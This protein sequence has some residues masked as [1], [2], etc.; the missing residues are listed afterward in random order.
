[1]KR[2]VV[3]GGGTGTTVTLSGLRTYEDIDLS[4]IVNMVD[5]GG[6]NRVVRDEFGLLPLSDLR[7]SI[8]ALAPSGNDILRQ[9]FTFRFSKGRG[10]KGHTL[11]NLVMIGLSEMRGGEVEAIEAMRTLFHVKGNVLPASLT[12]TTLVATYDDGAVVKGEHAIDEPE[13]PKDKKIVKV[14]LEPKP[15]PYERAIE[16]ILSSDVIIVGP[17]DLYTTIIAALLVP[18]M[19]EAIQSS[20]AKLVFVTNLMTKK[21]QTH[22]MGGAHMVT[23]LAKYTGREPDVVLLHRGTLPEKAT[24]AYIEKGEHPIIDDFSDDTHY[25]VVR[26]DLA[27]REEVVRDTGDVLTRSLV[28]HD[29]ERL[30]KALHSLIYP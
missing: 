20:K 6:S 12:K 30:G 15:K 4:V 5:D 2:V 24:Q 10:L 22:W 14:T 19:K 9:L 18:G 27:A 16:A 21:G 23:E 17:G 3:I 25:K 13:H 11:G 1:M 28:R 29:P 7:K 26:E 8:I